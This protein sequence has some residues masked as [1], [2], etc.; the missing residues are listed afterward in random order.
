MT[1]QNSIKIE[2]ARQCAYHTNIMKALTL[3]I[4]FLVASAA[5]AQSNVLPRVNENLTAYE[6]RMEAY[7]APQI[8]A[9]GVLALVT[10]ESSE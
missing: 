3:L 9:R 1:A 10:D 8:A 5:S 6:A 2:V 4:A 7:F